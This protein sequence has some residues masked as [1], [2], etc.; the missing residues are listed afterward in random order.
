MIIDFHV[1]YTPAEMMGSGQKTVVLKDE[2]GVPTYILHPRLGDL[3][4]HIEAM[5]RAGVD[6]A[7]LSSGAGL[8]GDIEACRL[9]NDRIREAVEKYPGRFAGLAH[10]PPLGGEAAFRE[11]ERATGELGFKGVAMESDVH[12]V[13]LDSRELW[14]FYGRVEGLGLFIFVHPSLK[15]LG[16]ELMQDFDLARS[17]GREFGLVMATIRLI[18]GGVLD[19]FPGLRVQMSH[20]GGGMAALM[21]R[22]R[23]YQDKEFW[24]TAGDMRHGKLPRRPFDEY[25]EQI[26]FDTGGFCGNINAVRSALLEMKPSQILFGTDYPQEIRGGP[27]VKAFIDD[28]RRMPVS[29]RDIEGILADNGRGLLGV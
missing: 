1:H 7:V 8:M 10:V 11:L 12:G 15:T 16:T 25:F 29:P 21:G 18:N 27:E 28:I 17:V 20:L 22:I 26:Y 23:S 5:D 2:H 9:V 4:Q 19:D 24:G 14:P 3:E 6:L 13:T